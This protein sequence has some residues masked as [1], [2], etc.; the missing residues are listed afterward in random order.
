MYLNSSTQP[1]LQNTDA[2]QSILQRE[3]NHKP[4]SRPPKIELTGLL[5]PHQSASQE[6]QP[7]YKLETKD[8]E[9]PLR[10][11][12]AVAMIAKKLE[13]EEVKVKG[14][15]EID[16]GIF[17]VEKI[18]LLIRD[19]TDRVSLVPVDLYFDFDHF[20]KMIAQ[21]GVVTLAPDGIASY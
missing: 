11:N 3:L 21:Y 5:L 12:T 2:F 10:M 7:M 16:E 17:D 15:L 1:S 9:Y 19:E 14:F 20:R 8:D 13:W 6:G 18:S 4:S